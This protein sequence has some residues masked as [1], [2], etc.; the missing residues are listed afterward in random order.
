MFLIA[1]NVGIF[2]I[3]VHSENG[4]LT[5]YIIQN[6]ENTTVLRRQ[7]RDMEK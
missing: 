2:F 5:K 1:Q 7:S 6:T 3:R 4:L